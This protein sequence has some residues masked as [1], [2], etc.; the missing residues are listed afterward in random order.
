[1][2][3]LEP[4][5]PAQDPV[6]GKRA[7]PRVDDSERPEVPPLEVDG[8]DRESEKAAREGQC[9]CRRM[10]DA[11]ADRREEDREQLR[12]AQSRQVARHKRLKEELL[13]I[14][15]AGIDE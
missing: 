10:D 7:E 5:V 4:W 2:I 14:S 9:P 8:R 3:Q 6:V 1:M 15:P 13:R 11:E 12:E